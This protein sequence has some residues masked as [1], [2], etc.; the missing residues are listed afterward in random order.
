MRVTFTSAARLEIIE[1]FDWYEN[2][3]V[4]LGIRL[5]AEIDRQLL[6]I[7]DHPQQFPKL[8]GD[9]RRARLQRFPYGL[10]F[11]ELGGNVQVIAF[12]HFSRDPMVWRGRV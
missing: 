2:E 9:V 8:L 6:R 3:S 1:A 5:Q 11:R 10:F 12:F 7:A 4:G